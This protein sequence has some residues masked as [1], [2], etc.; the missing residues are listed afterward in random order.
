M[1]ARAG[2]GLPMR[3]GQSVQCA[4]WALTCVLVALA[5]PGTVAFSLPAADAN[6]TFAG[7]RRGR[8]AS[9]AEEPLLQCEASCDAD[10]DQHC[11]HQDAD[12]FYTLGCDL[13]PT[14]SCD[15]LSNCA[16]PPSPPHPPT[17]PDNWPK[18][19]PTPPP[20]SPPPPSAVPW[21]VLTIFVIVLFLCCCGWLACARNTRRGTLRGQWIS[22]ACPCVADCIWDEVPAKELYSPP[23]ALVDG[24][25]V[26]E[27]DGGNVVPAIPLRDNPNG[28]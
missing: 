25:P 23:V 17:S 7:Q 1:E 22:G 3:V 11:D 21:I 20:P 19:P 5:P 15:D 10:Y 14:T 27:S 6:W 2:F 12:G 26:T 9:E 16:S 8:Q 13:H 18:N 4:A 24:R 28:A